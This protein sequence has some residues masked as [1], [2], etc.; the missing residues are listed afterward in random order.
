[1]LGNRRRTADA[2]MGAAASDEP[3]SGRHHDDDGQNVSFT[4]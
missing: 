3:A 2:D 4:F 1:M